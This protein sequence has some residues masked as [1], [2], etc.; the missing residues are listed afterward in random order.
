MIGVVRIL[1]VVLAGAAVVGCQTDGLVG[2][3]V[4]ASAKS[5]VI[6]TPKTA[7][8]TPASKKDSAKQTTIAQGDVGRSAAFREDRDVTGSVNTG[9]IN[10][11]PT[12]QTGGDTGS[13][14]AHT[15]FGNWTLVD[16][17]GR[18][19]RVILGGVLVGAAYSAR[20]EPDCPQAFAA[21]QSWEIQGAELV[22]RNQA[23]GIVGRLQPTG[24]SRFDGQGD[25]G[26]VYLIR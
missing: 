3:E 16:N 25:G 1:A 4:D 20:G 8:R 15:L 11:A 12:A 6:D 23:R 10:S 18:K 13:I 22:L 5:R 21:V 9:A 17:G 14:P 2:P 26:S 24:P 19:C 7:A